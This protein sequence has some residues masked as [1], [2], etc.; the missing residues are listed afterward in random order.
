MRRTEETSCDVT[1][2][3][4]PTWLLTIFGGLLPLFPVRQMVL[5]GEAGGLWETGG[6]RSLRDRALDK[7]KRV[8]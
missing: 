5:L 8:D 2:L 6:A 1:V 7:S 3:G 4:V